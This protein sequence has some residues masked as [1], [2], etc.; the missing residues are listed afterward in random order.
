MAVFSVGPLLGPVIGP[1]AGGF[2]AQ[3]IGF[4]WVFIIISCTS[5]LTMIIGIPVLVETYHPVLRARMVL[6]ATGDKQKA[7]NL[8]QGA[9]Q[10]MTKGQFLWVNLSRPMALL[11]QSFILNILSLFMA[12]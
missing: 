12:L 5:L 4:K 1:I 6:E 8:L 9:Y 2:V 11:W 3:E 7:Q 10:G